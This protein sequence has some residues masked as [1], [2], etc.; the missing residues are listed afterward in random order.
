MKTIK[1][2]LPFLALLCLLTNVFATPQ[3]KMAFVNMNRAIN[4]SEV[5]KRSKKIL[6]AKA[7]QTEQ[8]LKLKEQKIRKEEESLNNAFMLKEE[9]KAQKKASIENQKMELRQELTKT[10]RE[11]R[12]DERRHTANI[13]KDLKSI[14][15]S[16][17]KEEKYD[18]VVESN[19]LGAILFYKD[20]IVDV[21]DKVIQKYNKIQSLK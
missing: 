10:Q 7:K 3:M 18:L 4:E 1:L 19:L 21:T 8:M 12:A 9:A 15:E 2:F 11:F 5:G 6:E 20:N 14:I 13:F 17:S 16:I